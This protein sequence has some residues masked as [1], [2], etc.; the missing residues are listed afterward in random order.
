M[1]RGS[2]AAPLPFPDDDSDESLQAS[3][4][5]FWMVRA[6]IVEENTRASWRSFR[7]GYESMAAFYREDP[8]ARAAAQVR[9]A[10]SGVSSCAT[11]Q[12]ARREGRRSRNDGSTAGNCGCG[13]TQIRS[14]TD[15]SARNVARATT[16]A[17]AAFFS[18]LS[19]RRVVRI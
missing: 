16:K 18:S 19:L 8:A 2:S 7:A 13:S 14:T 11:L 12:E 9:I 5:Y 10:L 6:R 1:R 4:D 15:A 3:S 17:Q